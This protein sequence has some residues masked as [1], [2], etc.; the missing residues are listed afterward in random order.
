M[1]NSVLPQ[2]A[3][4]H[5]SVGRPVG[6]PPSVTSSRPLI[7]VGTF[8]SRVASGFEESGCTLPISTIDPCFRQLSERR[9]ERYAF[10]SKRRSCS[11]SRGLKM[12]HALNGKRTL[13][14]SSD[15]GNSRQAGIP[16]VPRVCSRRIYGRL[17][18]S[19]FATKHIWQ[20]DRGPQFRQVLSRCGH[21]RS[22]TP[23][24]RP[25]LA[26]SASVS[27]G[28]SSPSRAV[29]RVVARLDLARIEDLVEALRPAAPTSSR[30]M[31]SS[32]RALNSAS[33][34][35]AAMLSAMKSARRRC[36]CSVL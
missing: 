1:A 12:L 22:A 11:S 19:P 18:R 16:S 20:A 26:R 29:A 8:G 23:I 13:G 24:S 36:F 15:H 2:P 9:A 30:A 10:S 5:S 35:N 33:G 28:S 17:G 34:C 21:R 6:R 32:M 31:S 4:P 3:A 25:A 27:S 14:S 7:P